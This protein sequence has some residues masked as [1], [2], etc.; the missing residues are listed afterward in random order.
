MRLEIEQGGRQVVTIVDKDRNASWTVFP[1]RKAYIEQGSGAG[2]APEDQ[3]PNPCAAL[4][5]ATCRHT[6]EE[7][8]S[9]R[10]ADIWEITIRHDGR[11]L[12]GTQ[13]IDRERGVPLRQNMPGGLRSELS[14]VGMDEVGGRTVEQWQL[15]SSAENQEPISSYQWYDPALGVAVRQELPGG[16]V[17]ELKNIQLGDQPDELFRVPADFQKLTLPGP[18]HGER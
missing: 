9:G 7:E 5:D 10:T 8:I 15:T 14:M 4:S 17:S 16:Y 1:D 11:V 13:W 3:S 12:K 6:G 2:A 18:A